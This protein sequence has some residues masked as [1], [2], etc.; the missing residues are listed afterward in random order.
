MN[1]DDYLSNF[2]ARVLQDAMAEATATYWHRRARAFEAARPRP[3]DHLPAGTTIAD[4]TERDQRLAATAQACRHRA[5]MTRLAPLVA[6][7]HDQQHH[8]QDAA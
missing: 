7:E 5:A 4:L 6:H 2:R 8:H 1:L 3:G